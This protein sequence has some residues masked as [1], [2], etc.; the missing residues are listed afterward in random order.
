MAGVELPQIIRHCVMQK[1]RLHNQLQEI[2][3]I[4]IDYNNHCSTLTSF[5]QQLLRRNLYHVERDIRPGLERISWISLSINEFIKNCNFSK[6][7][8]FQKDFIIHDVT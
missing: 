6:S 5:E 2:E 8:K 7:H 3:G 1:D 4:I